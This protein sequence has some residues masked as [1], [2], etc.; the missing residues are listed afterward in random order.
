[1]YYNDQSPL[2]AITSDC[3][4]LCKIEKGSLFTHFGSKN[5][6]I[7]WGK[8]VHLCTIKCTAT[9]A[10]LIILS[11]LAHLMRVCF[12]VWCVKCAKYLAF[13]T[14][15]RADDSALT[16]Y[17]LA[18]HYLNSVVCLYCAALF[19]QFGDEVKQMFYLHLLVSGDWSL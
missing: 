10:C 17:C 4:N 18:R 19:L 6:H 13:G 7:S 15:E 9:V 5:T 3:V 11:H 12:C 16:V 2:R 14:F 1:M 8:I